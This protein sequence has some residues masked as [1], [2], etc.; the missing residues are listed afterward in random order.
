MAPCVVYCLPTSL[1]SYL[2]S[3]QFLFN[4]LV[5]PP[6]FLRSATA[7]VLIASEDQEGEST[8]IFSDDPLDET[9][10]LPA[11][12]GTGGFDVVPPEGQ[13]HGVTRR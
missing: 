4:N 12:L 7:P 11:D 8:P 9:A 6:Q 10:R 2:D 3:S 5:A 1:V 13:G